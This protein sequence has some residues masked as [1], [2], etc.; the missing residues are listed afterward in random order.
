MELLD[1]YSS[2]G[3]GVDV[4]SIMTLNDS[5]YEYAIASLE[6]GFMLFVRKRSL[7]T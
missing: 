2:R 4:V 1:V 7:I 5:Y 3:N 6:N